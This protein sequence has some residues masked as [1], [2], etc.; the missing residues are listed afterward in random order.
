[1]FEPLLQVPLPDAWVHD[2]QLPPAAEAGRR[3]R[4][5]LVAEV[6]ETFNPSLQ[7]QVDQNT[8]AIVEALLKSE[9]VGFLAV[10]DHDREIYFD[11]WQADP[12]AA[13]RAASADLA[14]GRIYTF[15][16]IARALLSPTVP[17][18]GLADRHSRGAES[19]RKRRLAALRD[20]HRAAPEPA[21]GLL[22]STLA[23]LWLAGVQEPLVP[24][25]QLAD[26]PAL[27]QLFLD[28]LACSAA[29]PADLLRAVRDEEERS[30][31]SRLAA[32]LGHRLAALSPAARGRLRDGLLDLVGLLLL[33]EPL[34][35][36]AI[37]LLDSCRRRLEALKRDTEPMRRA[38]KRFG[39]VRELPELFA[40]ARELGL[41]LAGYVHLHRLRRLIPSE[42][43]DP[44]RLRRERGWLVRS[45]HAVLGAGGSCGTGSLGRLLDKAV[46]ENDR[47]VLGS[48]RPLHACTNRELARFCELA[49]RDLEAGQRYR[50]LVHQHY[51][52]T[53]SL[54]GFDDR[55][56]RVLRRNLPAH[57][58]L[59]SARQTL[60]E[61]DALEHG[62]RHAFA[63]ASPAAGRIYEAGRTLET[64]ETLCR[65]ELSL[66]AAH[67][68]LTRPPRAGELVS[69]LDS[70]GER[71]AAADRAAAAQL[72]EQCLPPAC[73]FYEHCGE[74]VE[75]FR[76]KLLARMSERQAEAGVFLCGGFYVQAVARALG[77]EEVLCSIVTPR[78]APDTAT[79]DAPDR[80]A[81]DDPRALRAKAQALLRSVTFHFPG[82]KQWLDPAGRDGLGFEV[83]ERADAAPWTALQA[84]R[85]AWEEW[86]AGLS[87]Q[88]LHECR[89]CKRQAPLEERPLVARR[90]HAPNLVLPCRECPPE[91]GRFL[92]AQCA[93]REPVPLLPGHARSEAPGAETVE[94]LVCNLHGIPLG[95]ETQPPRRLS[96]GL[97]GHSLF[98]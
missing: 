29:V 41:D 64:L 84:R 24:L 58:A 36:A 1:M 6:Y 75:V 69:F 67:R 23:R 45:L 16:F 72:D 82:L 98:A 34:N 97:P 31:V 86:L 83:A 53:A 70:R 10:G 56:Y 27:R 44:H 76:R 61:L 9:K 2:V 22:R 95:D 89:N 87:G 91:T 26:W 19:A 35:R 65:E 12:R 66:E 85:V 50:P 63:A 7:R 32:A 74:L 77:R 47:F 38:E 18:F 17:L 46:R 33:N 62:I 15:D 13:A 60:R 4:V 14:A 37:P 49:A 51:L 8:V 90:G 57:E 5:V 81:P 20:L 96:G 79:E 11:P 28:L 80:E 21:P 52:N 54:L 73:D 39:A 40:V 3:R 88:A 68:V 55:E 94:I 92:C 59:G 71:L 25:S 42:D 93:G 78:L 30:A 43:L 48:P